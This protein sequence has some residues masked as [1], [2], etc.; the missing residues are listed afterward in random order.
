MTTPCPEPGCVSQLNAI[1]SAGLGWSLVGDLWWCPLHASGETRRLQKQR[2][3]IDWYGHM[4]RLR[5]KRTAVNE[6]LLTANKF[7]LRRGPEVRDHQARIKR[8][9]QLDEREL[10]EL[11]RNRD[12]AGPRHELENEARAAT[13]QR[14]ED[15]SEN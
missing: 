15:T 2:D 11:R 9:I 3:E 4:I 10:V 13:L 5:E 14:G 7:R 8:E 6:K 12:A 1:S